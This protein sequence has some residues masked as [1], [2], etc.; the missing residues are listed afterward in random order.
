MMSVLIAS[1]IRNHDCKHIWLKNNYIFRQTH[2]VYFPTLQV[3][4]LIIKE[5]L[6]D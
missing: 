2:F 3:S 5:Q 6:L 1:G 4:P